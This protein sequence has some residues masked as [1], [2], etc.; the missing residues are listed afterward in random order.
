M[1]GITGI[2]AHNIVGQ[3][4]MINL[5]N[6]TATLSSRGPDSQGY[7]TEDFIGLGHR[8]LSIL[9]TSFNGNQPFHDTTGR[10]HIVYNGE[11]Y[12]FKAL[13]SRLENDEQISF[14]S[15]TDTEVLLYLFIKYREKCLDLLNGFFAFAVYDK[16]KNELF[17]ARDRHGIK[18]LLYFNDDDK[19]IF[20]SELSTVLCYN[21]PKEI[22]KE[23]LSYY[24]QLQYIPA[25]L[26][27]IEN[28]HKLEPGHYL[29][30]TSEKTEKVKYYEVDTQSVGKSKLSYDEVQKELVHL[31]E[32]S[33]EDRLI[34]DVPVGTFLSGGIDSSIISAIA[35]KFKPDLKSF[36]IGYKDQP[37]YD[38]TNYALDVAKKHD[39]DHQ[40]FKLSEKELLEHYDDAL[41]Y[42]DEPFADSSAIAVYILS[43]LTRKEVTV[44]LSGDGAD[45]IFSGYNKHKAEYAIQKPGT[46]EKFA[47]SLSWLWKLL[48]Q[49][50]SSKLGNMARQLAKFSELQNLNTKSRYWKMAAI[51]DTD[52][53]QNLLLNPVL[54]DKVKEQY[55]SHITESSDIN[56][57]LL[58]D[59]QLV[60]PNDM[61]QKVDAMSMANSLEV[62][63]PFLDTRIV[64][65]AFSLPE[66]FKINA[67]MKKRI[68]QDAF[69][70]ELPGSLYQRPKHGFE[71]PVEKWLKGELDSKVK[72][73]ICDKELIAEQG[74]FNYDYLQSLLKKLHSR[75]PGDSAAQLWAVFCFQWWW[76]NNFVD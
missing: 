34:S 5:A 69:R 59:T 3:M 54:S 61:L 40:V 24:F 20:G 23:A 8:R 44:A 62:R 70:D 7:Y 64:D 52:H 47:Q 28:V 6:A 4:H 19:F 49:S 51:G 41:N 45:E 58:T 12:N 29:K 15:D 16:Q 67:Q 66:E 46:K 27:I 48:P 11:I 53:V 10:F 37:F 63:V 73:L 55:L 35:K 13:K 71:I 75:N 31:L 72:E 65:F 60:L 2:L 76:K 50:R 36:S 57:V 32:K 9:D 38:E 26:S 68:L 74:L 1:C 25:P 42:M 22:N 43:K 17:L 14:E 21:L 56:N 39:I 33:V 18:P 30:V